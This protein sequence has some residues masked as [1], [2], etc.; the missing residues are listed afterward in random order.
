MHWKH[1]LLASSAL[2]AATLSAT[3]AEA[4]SRAGT[5]A[6]ASNTIE[7]LVV[8]AEK[9]E[10]SLQ[11]VPVAVTAFT[12]EKRDLVG[13]N[14]VQDITNFTPGLQYSTQT[15]RISLRGVGRLNNSHAA[16]SSVAVYAD[17]IYS[18]STVQAGETPIF[19]DRT[20]V[21]RGPQGTLYGRNSIG[22]AINIVSRRPTEDF[23]GE[24][25]GTYAN[26]NRTLIEAAVSGPITEGIQ[27]RL[28][29]N[30]EKQRK[31]W[32]KNVST[33][34][35]P[36]EG[37]VVDTMF[38]EG[39]LQ[40]KF[41]DRLDTWVKLSIIRWDN[42][43]GGPGSIS[44]W[45]PT[46]YNTAQ[47]SQ[48]NA[49]VPNAGFAYSGLATN[50]NTT[51]PSRNPSLDDPW[52]FCR[53]TPGTVRLTDTYI[54]AN[55]WN[56]HG[57]NFDLKYITG[58]TRYHYFLTGDQDATGVLSYSSCYTQSAATPAA[59]GPS[60]LANCVAGATAPVNY[61]TS[62]AFNY[63]ENERW[64]SHE[65]N[66]VST[67]DSAFQYLLGAYYYTESYE[68][69]VYTTLN[70]PRLAGTVASVVGGLAPSDTLLRIYDDRPHLHIRSRAVFGQ[71]DWKFAPTLKTTLGIRFGDDEKR[72]YESLR[73]V[74]A[75][76]VFNA[77]LPVDLTPVLGLTGGKGVTGVTTDSFG[78]KTRTYDDKWS[79][80][81]G[82]AGLEWSPTEE[83][84]VYGKYSRGYKAGGFRIGIDTSLGADPE[85]KKET[86]DSYEIGLKTTILNGT[87]QINGDI[88]YYQYKNAQVPLSQPSAT[89][90]AAAN[91]ILFNV[92]KAV[93]KG[94]EI[95]TIWQQIDNLQIL[96]NYSYLDAHIQDGLAVDG[97][98]SCAQAPGA[99]RTV[100]TAVTDGFCGGPQFLQDLSGNTL[101]NSAKNRFTVN[102]NYTWELASGKVT[103]SGTY[104][105]RS[106]Q[107][108]SIF[109]R[110]YYKAPSFDQIDARL[111][112][113]PESGKY[114]VILFG[115]NLGNDLGYANGATASRRAGQTPTVAALS[116]VFN[117][118][119]STTYELNPPR[120]YGI[121]LQFRY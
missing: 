102:A 79:A 117:P 67:N 120:T 18:T 63:Q 78:F 114:T 46:P 35:A 8:T 12:S 91:S 4:Q 51:C 112:W 80:T 110:A 22:G 50:V 49:Q 26:Y 13:I 88:F 61:P 19:I 55:H 81:T 92:P 56:Y 14:S 27:F 10:Q 21:L 47:Q 111:T 2:L 25:R 64:W 33:S 3:V 89:A 96:A 6:A 119:Q 39:Q 99:R 30:W 58:G 85:T 45:T 75:P 94:V 87:L 31:G 32:F 1:A 86:L 108:G 98:D 106:A 95:E 15:D 29:G 116:G 17:G 118:A 9:R 82:T 11:D 105:W 113:K 57:D 109:D 115:K 104:I 68:Q 72:G 53:N 66:L 65:I 23:Y 74:A 97:A 52:T 38:L 101:P 42:G 59:G 77:N 121:E 40:F 73:L 76:G 20:E 5:S 83:T 16:D 107:Y 41:N 28:A 71:I 54:F 103:A 70:D 37:G 69:P 36:D 34:G 100:Q 24:V 7:E 43:G 93:S 90:G 44:S 84:L 48:S 60:P 62:Y